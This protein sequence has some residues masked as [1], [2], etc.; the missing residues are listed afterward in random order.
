V[1]ITEGGIAGEVIVGVE[2][3][4]RNSYHVEKWMKN[5]V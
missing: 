5:P 1:D 4:G 3:G 2:P